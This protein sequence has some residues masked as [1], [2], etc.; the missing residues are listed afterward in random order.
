MRAHYGVAPQLQEQLD[1]LKI[2]TLEA[3]RGHYDEP[4]WKHESKATEEKLWIEDQLTWN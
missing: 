3:K 1:E 4:S 2:L